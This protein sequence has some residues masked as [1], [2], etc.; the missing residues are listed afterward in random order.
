MSPAHVLCPKPNG[1]EAETL[2]GLTATLPVLL[3]ITVCAGLDCPGA[4]TGK[5]SCAGLTLIVPVPAPFSAT[6]TALTPRD[7]EETARVAAFPPVANGLKV[8]S[9]V[10][11]LP[12]TSFAPQVAAP[13]EKLPAAA[14]VMRKS[15][16]ASGAPPDRKSTRLN[17]S[18]LGISYAVF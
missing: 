1:G 8:T 5:V 3:T 6:V 9:T 13:H 17:S 7:E 14:P 15:T 2:S 10:Q 11:L 4:T 12:L 16:L 18:H